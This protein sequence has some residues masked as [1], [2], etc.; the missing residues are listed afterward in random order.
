MERETGIEPATNSLEGCDSTIELLPP[1]RWVRSHCTT[2][3]PGV[4]TRGNNLLSSE[5]N[6][7]ANESKNLDERGYVELPGFIPHLLL[8]QLRSSVDALFEQEGENA[9]AE[10]RLEPGSRRLANLVAKGAVFEQIV[11]MP[12]ILDYIEAILGPIFKL[13]SL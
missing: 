9:G 3:I 8:E 4:K 5:R 2:D 7:T 6:V 1:G 11:C 12:T 10:F 13:S